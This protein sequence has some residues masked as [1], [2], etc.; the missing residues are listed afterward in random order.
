[1][2]IFKIINPKNRYMRKLTLIATVALFLSCENKKV[3]IVE[4]IKKTKNELLEARMISKSYSYAASKLLVYNIS[5]SDSKKYG[6]QQIKE[7][8]QIYKKSYERAIQD[9]K[10]V[11]PE[12]LKSQ[13]KL[14]SIAL[15][16][17]MKTLYLAHKIDSL[18]LELKKY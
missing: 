11:S 2:L 8:A 7:Y 5:L 9:L 13:K 3:E 18:E 14:D 12:I 17:E 10:G 15:V 16:Y 1:M 4:N 6:S